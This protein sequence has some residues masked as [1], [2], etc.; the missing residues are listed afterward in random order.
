MPERTGLKTERLGACFASILLLVAQ[1]L[2]PQTVELRQ[3]MDDLPLCSALRAELSRG[4][5]GDGVDQPYMVKM[6]QVGVERALL[7]L[8]ASLR[9]T[10]PYNLHVAERSYFRQFDSPDSQITDEGALKTIE[11][12]GLAAELESIAR[13]R[14]LVAPLFRGPDRGS[15]AHF[16]RR[17]SSTVDFF[18]NPWLPQH[19]PVLGWSGRPMP[20][21]RAVVNGDAIE[22]RAQLQSGKLKTKDLNRALSAAVLSQYDN[23][24]VIKLLLDSGADVNARYGDRATPLMIATSHPCNLRPLLDRGADLTARDASGR[25]ALDIARQMKEDVAVRL[26]L[27]ASKKESP[28]ATNLGVCPRNSL[29]L[30]FPMAL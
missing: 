18:G 17:V 28:D 13:A 8:D 27:Q 5:G 6:R 15:A 9:G 19:P 12:S 3:L 21:T 29:P 30:D 10:K 24:T 1:P 22:T 11:T 7:I 25:T 14:V 2:T 16:D 23:S 4:A 20:L 26:L